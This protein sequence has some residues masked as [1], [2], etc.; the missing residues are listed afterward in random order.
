MRSAFRLPSRGSTSARHNTFET[1]LVARVFDGVRLFLEHKKTSI[2]SW[3]NAVFGAA[4]N[5]R[6]SSSPPDGGEGAE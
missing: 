4:V 1:V 3:V 6:F 2:V 5:H